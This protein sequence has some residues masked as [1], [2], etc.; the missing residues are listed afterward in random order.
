[1]DCGTICGVSELSYLLHKIN[2][3]VEAHVASAT[4][5]CPDWAPIQSPAVS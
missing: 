5:I 4:L 2:A 3:T 1:M